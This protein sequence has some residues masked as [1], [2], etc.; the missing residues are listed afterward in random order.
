MLS[1]KYEL[2]TDKMVLFWKPP[3]VFGQW[4]RSEFE[5][6]GVKYVTAEQFMMAEKARLF[7]DED[8]RNQILDTTD[9]K[10]QKALGRQVRNFDESRWR[11]VRVEIVVKG[12]VAKFSQ[13]PKMK[14]ELLATG[15]RCLV[16][17]SPLGK[18]SVI[19]S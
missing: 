3:S 2:V 17:A 11:E 18:L 15:D 9:P 4:T 13:N 16:E 10:L 12:N 19:F 6:D 8:V 14:L 1:G 7:G 5:V